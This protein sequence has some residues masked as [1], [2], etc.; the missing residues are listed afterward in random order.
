MKSSGEYLNEISAQLKIFNKK[1]VEK[2]CD[3]LVNE[4]FSSDGTFDKGDAKRIMQRLRS[5][6]CFNPC[7][8]WAMPSFRLEDIPITFGG[9]MPRH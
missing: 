3:E 7:K 1:A 8:N 4:L 6:E 5:K 9:N 2:I